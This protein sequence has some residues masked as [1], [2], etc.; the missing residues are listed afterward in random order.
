MPSRA[1]SSAIFCSSRRQ[2][3]LSSVIWTMKCLPTFRLLMT[4]PTA[5]AMAS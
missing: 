2:D 5:R 1:A 4:V 3:R